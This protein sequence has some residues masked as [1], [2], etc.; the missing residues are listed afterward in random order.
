MKHI[1]EP[2]L[3]PWQTRAWDNLYGQY[4]QERFPH[5]LLLQGRE[6]IGSDGFAYFLAKS[7]LCEQ[8][9]KEKGACHQCRACHLFAAE[10]H[11]NF[12]RISPEIN[13]KGKI[14]KVIRVDQIRSILSAVQQTGLHEGRKVLIISP[15]ESMNPASANALLKSLEE[16]PANT[17]FIL[18]SINSAGLMAT[19][20]SRCQQIKLPSATVEQAEQWL[21]RHI[22]QQDRIDYLLKI[23]HGNP[24]LVQQWQEND[25][26]ESAL[27]F[28]HELL[29]I[30]NNRASIFELAANWQKGQVLQYIK[31]WWA[32]LSDK[33]KE[34]VSEGGALSGH[35][36][37]QKCLQFL[38]RLL[39]SKRQLESSANPNEQLMLE[40][41][42]IDWQNLPPLS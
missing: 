17:F 5:A 4:R 31:W 21:G 33:L 15:A 26:L 41:L 20:R 37:Q 14:S 23:S 7:L 24:L 36:D 28:E 11:P 10:T 39:Q 1:P 38:D 35:P 19:I 30:Q 6:S 9:D 27:S 34:Q 8:Q 29:Q 32:W 42:L 25:L 18:V 40:S 22:D 2:H 16:P 13:D 12:N 3:Y